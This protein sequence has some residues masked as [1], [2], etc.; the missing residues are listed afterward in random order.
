MQK[1]PERATYKPD[2]RPL[3]LRSENL[4][5]SQ[6]YR[7][8]SKARGIP[9]GG[10]Q[11]DF[12]EYKP[13]NVPNMLSRLPPHPLAWQGRGQPVWKGHRWLATCSGRRVGF[14]KGSKAKPISFQWPTERLLKPSFCNKENVSLQW[15]LLCRLQPEHW[16][17]CV[18]WT[19][20]PVELRGWEG[21]DLW[22]ANRIASSY[23][24]LRT[25]TATAGCEWW[26]CLSCHLPF[27]K[28]CCPVKL[29]C[30]H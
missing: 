17:H 21:M 25:I 5:I 18:Q 29:R 6:S 23:P 10:G 7:R 20:V 1:G 11:Q 2:L 26:Q 8:T 12:P 4:S 28:G 27:P 19:N 15:L 13:N 30:N 3:N 16:E 14:T 9:Q 22:T 24:R